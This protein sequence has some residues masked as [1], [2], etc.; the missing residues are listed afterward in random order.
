[1]SLL[2]SSIVEDPVNNDLTAELA[3]IANNDF[4]D[5]LCRLSER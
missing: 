4:M 2:V 1:M 3:I 5:L